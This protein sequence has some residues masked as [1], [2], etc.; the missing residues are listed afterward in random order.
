M[1]AGTTPLTPGAR[2]VEFRS[3]G[4]VSLREIFDVSYAVHRMEEERARHGKGRGF[5]NLNALDEDEE[6]EVLPEANDS[7]DDD[8]SI[9]DPTPKEKKPSSSTW[10]HVTEDQVS[11]VQHDMQKTTIS[12]DRQR[13]HPHKQHAV[14]TRKVAT[15]SKRTGGFELN[16]EGSTLFSRRGVGGK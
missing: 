9:D 8:S 2:A 11:A 16:L 5:E 15:P 10:S 1:Q 4:S 6:L 13:H 7:S 3:P 12:K 14:D